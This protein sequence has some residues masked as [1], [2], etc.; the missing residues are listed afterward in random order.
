MA[1]SWQ[2]I[3]YGWVAL[4]GIVLTGTTIY[5]AVNTRHHVQQ[6]DLIPIAL[7]TY[8]RCLATQYTN[9]PILYRVNPPS[10]VR[11]W[12]N[13]NGVAE[14]V[15]NAFGYYIDKNMMDSLDTTITQLVSYFTDPDTIIT[16]NGFPIL[17]QNYTVTGLWD[18]LDIGDGINQFTPY[19]QQIYTDTLQ[20]RYKVLQALNT[21]VH[22]NPVIN[23][24]INTNY[25]AS[26]RTVDAQYN[27]P[28]Y[29]LRDKIGDI[30]YRQWDD[31]IGPHAEYSADFI[32]NVFGVN[33]WD[34]ELYMFPEIF[35]NQPPW[36]EKNASATWSSYF[37]GTVAKSLSSDD[38]KNCAKWLWYRNESTNILEYITESTN[39]YVSG[40]FGH[41]F[42][43]EL[44]TNNIYGVSSYGPQNP[45]L[46]QLY[47][48]YAVSMYKRYGTYQWSVSEYNTNIF[49]STQLSA[50]VTMD[51]NFYFKPSINNIIS[52]SNYEV[53][54]EWEEGAGMTD[55]NTYYIFPSSDIYI[56]TNAGQIYY[57][58]NI[59][60]DEDEA[61][62]LENSYPYM[63]IAIPTSVGISKKVGFF[64]PT[65]FSGRLVKYE[66]NFQYCTNKYW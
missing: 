50:K 49:I 38:V 12:I 23:I 32:G 9:N 47:T 59:G 61:L 11:S 40:S 45:L 52:A 18:K 55:T 43:V 28:F 48:T 26:L 60:W 5:V 58:A 56:T 54:C 10:F 20:E 34:R 51:N 17:F 1:F 57:N 6:I 62:A 53:Y 7:G 65:T 13:T 46:G 4:T 63:D 36:I 35:T 64:F 24:S 33:Y 21:I 37:T 3:K 30:L 2:Q 14:N 39:S 41:Y 15:T 22:T 66:Y 31:A 44:R 27:F 8:E 29:G 25:P 16:S 19:V 42:I